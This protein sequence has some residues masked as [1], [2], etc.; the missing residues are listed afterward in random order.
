VSEDLKTV[1]SL[2]GAMVGMVTLIGGPVAVYVA[3][4]AAITRLETQVTI[5]V[6]EIQELKGGRSSHS[7]GL[8]SVRAELAT[9]KERIRGLERVHTG[10]PTLTGQY[11][12]IR[13]PALG[14]S[15]TPDS[16]NK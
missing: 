11:A 2:V 16:G 6:T 12:T 4:K 10:G 9:L 8:G 14:G 15:G 7:D 3:M 1:L 13:H 5:L